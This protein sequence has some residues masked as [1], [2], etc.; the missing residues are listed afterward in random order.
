MKAR[1]QGAALMMALVILLI[2]TLIGLS[3]MQTSTL[4]MKIVANQK[5]N[6]TAFH[7][8]ETALEITFENAVGDISS[9]ADAVTSGTQT[10]NQ[11]SYLDMPASSVSVDIYSGG[12]GVWAKGSSIGKIKPHRYTVTANAERTGSR[13]KASH[14]RGFELLVPGS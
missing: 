2:M 1:Q 10:I 9:F 7:I 4:D 8:A 3:A 12:T 6:T 11:T 13:A 5:E 14:Q